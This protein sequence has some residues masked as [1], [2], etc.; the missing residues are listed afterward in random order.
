MYSID[1]QIRRVKKQNSITEK[2][3]DPKNS[4]DLSN[5]S[6]Y[7]SKGK[8]V[9]A[10]QNPEDYDTVF[11]VR[12]SKIRP[13]YKCEDF[14]NH[15]F[16]NAPDKELFLKHIEFHILGRGIKFTQGTSD[17]VRQWLENKKAA[18]Q[19]NIDA[20]NNKPTYSTYAYALILAGI[21]IDKKG[22]GVNDQIN[23]AEKFGLKSGNT[24][25]NKWNAFEKSIAN[26]EKFQSVALD[27]IKK[28]NLK[29]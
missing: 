1:K 6:D 16:N 7:N 29:K 12:L 13:A 17:Y 11:A 19:R 18:L 4:H 20:G 26:P 2:A 14:L 24:L 15:H 23:Y 9:R 5:G 25:Y 27:I 28:H 22:F 3:I 21:N 10:A 8:V